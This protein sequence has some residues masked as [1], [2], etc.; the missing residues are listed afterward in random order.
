MA[1]E[2]SLT[3]TEIVAATTR[4]LRA[5]GYKDVERDFEK[6]SGVTSVRVFEDPYSFV[7][8]VV[9]E[10]WSAL[11]S[12]WIDAQT[13]LVNLMSQAVSSSEPK[14]WDGYLV[15]CTP[16]VISST[17]SVRAAKIEYDTSRVRKLLVT[18][19]DLRNVHDVE[20]ALQPLLPLNVEARSTDRTSALDL[21]EAFLIQRGFGQ[22]EVRTLVEAF[23]SQQPLVEALHQHLEGSSS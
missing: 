23:R 11:A 21:L 19:D 20:R 8:I 12:G 13:A 2:H 15:L 22:G 7:S 1:M 5:G 14:A 17:D 4:A 10:T 6:T 18:G 3:T 9:Y 16:S